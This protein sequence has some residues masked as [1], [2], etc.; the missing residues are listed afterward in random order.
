VLYSNETV[1]SNS[2]K[3]GIVFAFKGAF[4]RRNIEITYIRR[5]FY[6]SGH[7]TPIC[8]TLS[9]TV[10]EVHTSVDNDEDD[11]DDDS[12]NNKCSK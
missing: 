10:R 3:C 6:S 11:D 9:F 5:T 7:S 2:I 12:N 1:G 4:R 8:F